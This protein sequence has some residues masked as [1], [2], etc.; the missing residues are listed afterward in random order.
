MATFDQLSAE[1]KA[2]LELVLKR[3][4]SYDQLA[5]TLGMSESRVRDLAR[6]ALVELAP[7]SARRVEQ[8][9]RGQLAD[10]VLGQQT[11]PESTATRGHL[12]RSEAARTWTRSLLDSLDGLYEDGNLPA[13][14]DPE[15]G[16]PRRE[17]TEARPLIPADGR[18]RRLYA[19]GG[20]AALLILIVVLLWPIGVLTGGDDG[21]GASTAS[22]API[23][24]Q[25]RGSAQ[26]IRQGSTL[27]VQITAQG[28]PEL[29]GQQ[30]YAAWLYNSPRDVKLIGPV[31][32]AGNGAI[33]GLGRLPADYEKYKFIDVSRQS[34]S[35]GNRHSGD[36]VLR[37]LVEKLKKPVTRG[38]GKKAVSLLANIPLVPL[39]SQGGGGAG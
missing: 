24:K 33:G 4:R 13:I 32:S 39:P 31:P 34:A 12:R 9:W 20:A 27:A 14:P 37:G 1:Q 2:I 11:G 17:R 35:T 29:S 30:A 6:D 21:G 3:G 22:S 7:L 18:R 23:N 28:L 38:K 5:D 19:G 10:Y 8:D 16:R 15:R 26:I 25:A 36:S